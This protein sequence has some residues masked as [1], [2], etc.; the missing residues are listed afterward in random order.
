MTLRAGIVGF[1]AIGAVHQRAIEACDGIELVAVA[2]RRPLIPGVA[3]FSTLESMLST[4]EFDVLVICTPSGLHA[5]QAMEGL[6]SGRHVVIEKPLTLDVDRGA[7]VVDEARK[8]GLTVAVISQRRFEPATIAIERVIRSGAAGRPLW[9]EV[10][11]R[12]QRDRSYYA[13]GGWRG[14]LDLDGGVLMNQAIHA[15]DLVR[16]FLGPVS[17]ASATQATLTHEI[18]TGDAAAGWLTFANG[19]LAVVL[20]TTAA[21]HGQ[22][23]EINLWFERGQIALRDDSIATW[24]VPVPA[25]ISE[26]DERGSGSQ[27]P[28]GITFAG[29]LAQW[30]DIVNSIERGAPS[31]VP[32]EEGLS[33]AA[34]I[35]ALQESAI[36]GH[37]VHPRFQGID[38]S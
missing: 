31:Q 26:G 38:G 12:W 7:A 9:A 2:T 36:R 15:I 18:A 10:L 35:V 13:A 21:P 14:T 1:G 27:R 25:P 22:P 20:A 23:A 11:I 17:A 33:T 34:V 3:C 37:R 29:H 16:W 19:A 6:Q 5:G 30:R 28:D 24:T 32:G 8:R 4:A